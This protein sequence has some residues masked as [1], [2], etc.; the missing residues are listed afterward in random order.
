MGKGYLY[1]PIA[2]AS[3]GVGIDWLIGRR[4]LVLTD[5]LTHTKGEIPLSDFLS[6]LNITLEDC[7]KALAAVEG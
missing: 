1:L 6:Q 5:L 4:S 7:Q 3:T 2:E